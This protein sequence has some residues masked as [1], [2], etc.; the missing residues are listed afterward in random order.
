MESHQRHLFS[1]T[2][3]SIRYLFLAL[4][5]ERDEESEIDH[6]PQYDKN[7]FIELDSDKTM[8]KQP[9]QKR[10]WRLQACDLMEMEN[11]QNGKID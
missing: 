1:A 8:K 4:Q 9:Q 11:T 6:V 3:F 2:A 10:L 5:S 7:E